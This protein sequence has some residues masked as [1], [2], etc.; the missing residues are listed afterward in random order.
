M[1][2]AGRSG[3]RIP[4]GAKD[5]SLLRIV[6][7]DCGSN[8]TSCAMD[9]GVLC[10]WEGNLR[11]PPRVRM[12]GAIPLLPVYAL[13]AWRVTLLFLQFLIMGDLS[14]IAREVNMRSKKNANICYFG[15]FTYDTP[16]A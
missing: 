7:T 14:H 8:T 16:F 1:Q 12:S 3:V 6:Q 10:G 11:L 15:S 5:F 4:A 13:M 9:A 2:K